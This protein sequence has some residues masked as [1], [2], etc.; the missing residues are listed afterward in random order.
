MIMARERPY[1]RL[2][3]MFAEADR[4][5]THTYDLH[6][7][8]IDGVDYLEARL[9][10]DEAI[11][12]GA[13]KGV[14]VEALV[15]MAINKANRMMTPVQ[16]TRKRFDDEEVEPPK[17]LQKSPLYPIGEGDLVRVAV[18]DEDGKM[19]SE[20][21]DYYRISMT[22]Q[23]GNGRITVQASYERDG[24]PKPR[25]TSRKSQGRS[26]TEVVAR[27]SPGKVYLQVYKHYRQADLGDVG[28]SY[29]DL[30]RDVKRATAALAREATV[31]PA[32]SDGTIFDDL[33]EGVASEL[34]P[35]VDKARQ[36]EAAPAPGPG[37]PPQRVSPHEKTDVIPQRPTDTT[38]TRLINLSGKSRRDAYQEIIAQ[39]E[40]ADQAK[41]ADGRGGSRRKS[42]RR[43][44]RKPFHIQPD[45]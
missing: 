19:V 43:S 18:L 21:P 3:E 29:T 26:I 14:G 2:M 5:S 32:P 16:P 38:S 9:P 34:G 22:G 8:S 17:R 25:D 20:L 39:A 1:E 6:K 44:S 12:V 27:L 41:E 4:N 35:A 10:L 45:V 33:V 28:Y 7:T 36:A 15:E 24:S 42:G 11:R 31:S 23:N 30:K 13:Y 40:A 37:S